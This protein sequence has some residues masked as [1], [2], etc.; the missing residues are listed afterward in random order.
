VGIDRDPN[1]MVLESSTP[2]VE[3]RYQCLSNDTADRTGYPAPNDATSET[4]DIAGPYIG[5]RRVAG[6]GPGM[7]FGPAELDAVA[8]KCPTRFRGCKRQGR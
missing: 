4:G 8:P 5:N 7:V 6:D 2:Y 1:P 3:T